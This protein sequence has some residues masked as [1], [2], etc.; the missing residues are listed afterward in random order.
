[1]LNGRASSA[2]PFL[3]VISPVVPASSREILVLGKYHQLA[4]DRFYDKVVAVT[5]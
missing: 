3:F 2:R 5:F 4:G 1:M